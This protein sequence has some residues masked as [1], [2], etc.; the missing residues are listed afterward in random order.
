MKRLFVNPLLL[1]LVTL[2]ALLL[3]M[4]AAALQLTP[5][6][7][8]TANLS[9]TLVT[10]QQASATLR[11]N[12]TLRADQ[13]RLFRVSPVVDGLV[14]ELN[15][16]EQ[17]QVHKGQ[18][19]ARLYSNTLGQAQADYLAALAHYDVAEADYQ[20]IKSLREDGVVSESRLIAAD[21]QYKTAHAILDQ[22]QRALTLAGMTP[23]Q[24]EKIAQHPDNIAEYPLISPADGVLL[25]VS[26]ENGQMLA[27]G[28]SAFRI[29]DLSV[30]WANVR[31]PVARIS[32]VQI[33]AKATLKVAAFPQLSF[34]GQLETLSGEVDESSQTLAGRVV[35]DN[36]QGLL[37]PGMY[38]QAQ[39]EGARYSGLMVP[40]SALFR[41]GNDNYLFVVTGPGQYQPTK[42]TAM[43]PQGG[44]VKIESGISAGAEV[45]SGGVA[46][47]K[48][49]WQYQGGE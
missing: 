30:I 5:Q 10:E 1:T 49:H 48:S 14:T 31:I 29:A 9:T 39:L 28:E 40:E 19:L 7:I 42:V 38:V 17:T 22:H 13:Q 16:V 33:G 44:W 27:A 18:V 46:E 15:V 3:P 45:V 35:I 11:V 47:L 23:A 32:D 41:R 21:S 34:S 4:A 26:A 36:K 37:R 43:P 20:R 12:G 2:P 6:Q 8:S 24:I 25:T